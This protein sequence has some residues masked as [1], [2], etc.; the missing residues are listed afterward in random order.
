MTVLQYFNA[1]SKLIE[2]YPECMDMTVIYSRDDEGNG[3]Q[4]VYNKPTLFQV[5]TLEDRDL[6]PD[7]DDDGE[8]RRPNCVIIN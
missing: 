3:Y 5:H 2:D 4:E 6:E 1:L 7:F 8:I